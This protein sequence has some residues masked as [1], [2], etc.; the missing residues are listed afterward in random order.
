MP[1]ITMKDLLSVFNESPLS[2][3]TIRRRLHESPRR[4]A[5]ALRQAIADNLI[6]RVNP[7]EVGSGKHKASVYAKC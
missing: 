4:V 3:R 1:V 5:G 7:I 2:A 6:R